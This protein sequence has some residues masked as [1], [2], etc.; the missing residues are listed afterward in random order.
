MQT[1]NKQY[2]MPE[3]GEEHDTEVQISHSTSLPDHPPLILLR[4]WQAKA[5]WV[6]VFNSALLFIRDVL[7]RV[8]PLSC[9]NK[10]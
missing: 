3:C 8:R 10:K 9:S 6:H 7:Q 1:G 2:R 4:L 5:N